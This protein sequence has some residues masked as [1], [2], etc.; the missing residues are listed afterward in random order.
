[1]AHGHR[2]V[3]QSMLVDSVALGTLGART[4]LTLNATLSA[5]TATFLMKRVRYFLQLTGRTANDDGPLLVFLNHGDATAS[6]VA[7]AMIEANTSGP[8]DVTQSLTQDETWIVYQNTVRAIKID[9]LAAEGQL[10]TGWIDLNRKKG[11]P[12]VEGAGV[13]CSILNGGS[14]ALATG[15]L[16]NGIVQMQGVW[17][18][19]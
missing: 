10:I 17:L 2:L 4:A 3:Q 12:A 5:L 7:A 19:D 14:A 18:R 13:T 11:I 16:V 15:S 1:M 8:E 6:E 9:A